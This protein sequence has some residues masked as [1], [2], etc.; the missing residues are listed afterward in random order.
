MSL[1]LSQNKIE[2]QFLRALPSR[3]IRSRPAVAV[4]SGLMLFNNCLAP[5]EVLASFNYMEFLDIILAISWPY[6]IFGRITLP[7][8]FE[9]DRMDVLC[10][11]LLRVLCCEEEP[12]VVI[13]FLSSLVHRGKS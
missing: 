12:F 6:G 4:A 3:P 7:R 2:G 5:A 8:A 13:E 1:L 9:L 11:S 10:G